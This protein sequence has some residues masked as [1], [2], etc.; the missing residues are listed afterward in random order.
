MRALFI[1]N[2]YDQQDMV[3]IDRA[4]VELSAYI[5]LVE[6]NEASPELRGLIRAT[7]ALIPVVD[8]LQGEYIKGE[9]INGSLL[10]TATLYKWLEQEEAIIHGQQTQRLDGMIQAEKQV[11]VTAA[12]DAM[13]T[14]MM[15]RGVLEL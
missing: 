9:S 11:A 14:D 2:K 4:K 12:Q 7:P 10:V 8:D 15:D 13:M 1:Y 6:I 3:V 5:Q